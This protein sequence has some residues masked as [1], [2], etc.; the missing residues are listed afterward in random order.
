MD[1]QGFAA[2]FATSCDVGPSGLDD[3]TAM[4][5]WTHVSASRTCDSWVGGLYRVIGLAELVDSDAG[6]LDA[7]L[8]VVAAGI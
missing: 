2:K 8:V 5:S 4:F 3:R 6:L 7:V 1:S